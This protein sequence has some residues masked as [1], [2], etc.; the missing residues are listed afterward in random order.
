MNAGSKSRIGLVVLAVEL[1]VALGACTPQP[2]P[3]P[4]AIPEPVEF[5]SIHPAS[6][7]LEIGQT[8]RFTVTALDRF[9]N[10]VLLSVGALEFGVNDDIGQLNREC[11]YPPDSANFT[12]GRPGTVTMRVNTGRV[13]T[14]AQARS[15]TATITVVPKATATGAPRPM[16]SPTPTIH[17]SA[18]PMA[19]AVSMGWTHACAL[20]LTGVRC[21]GSNDWGQLGGGTSSDRTTPR[22]VT[23][24]TGGVS[25][26]SAGLRHTCVLTMSRGV[27]C[28]GNNQYGLLGDGTVMSSRS[29]VDVLGLTSGVAA[30][31]AGG[32]YTCALTTQGG[33]R[34][35]GWS[36]L[37]KT[38]RG[39]ATPVDVQGLTGGVAAVSVG[40]WHTCV[41]TMTGGVKCWGSNQYGQ[42]GDGTTMD[43]HRP[44]DVVGL[45][46]H[47]TSVS[48]GGTHTCALTV[49]GLSKCWGRGSDGQLGD[50]LRTAYRTKPMDVAGL[51]GEVIA[52]SAGSF[53]TCV[54]TTNGGVKCWG[55][56]VSDWLGS[57][58]TAFRIPPTDVVGLTSGVASVSVGVHNTCAVS[59]VGG[60]RCW[61]LNKAGA[62]GDG[63]NKDRGTPTHVIGF[64]GGGD[65]PGSDTATEPS[66]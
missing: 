4:T 51:A 54:L 23:G 31:S 22:K 42:L 30:I 8:Q 40:G 12:A 62:L 60:V 45:T 50:G 44:V 16:A 66:E 32:L 1:V 37:G 55:F 34:C 29:P 25:A 24:L 27:K 11:E 46:S 9:E 53:H 6:V 57:G 17:P 20:A 52:I 19:T 21:W 33:V 39:Q 3:A 14:P 41:L 59:D 49:G 18:C 38:I 48:A 47:V 5:L 7:T 61:G 63:T 26:V 2:T 35:W 13:I 36:G 15:A 10:P 64:P 65:A 43:S 56:N 58:T 28:W